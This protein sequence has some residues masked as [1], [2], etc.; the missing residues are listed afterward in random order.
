MLGLGEVVKLTNDKEYMVVN[1]L[2][3]HNIKYAY[4]MSVSKPLEILIATIKNVAGTIV[5]E[6]VKDNDELDYILNQFAINT[7]ID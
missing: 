5:L 2:E 6:E 3:L 1:D 4:L 7:K